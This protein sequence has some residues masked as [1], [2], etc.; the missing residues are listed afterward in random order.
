MAVLIR[1]AGD[2]IFNGGTI[3]RA[4]GL[5]E[6]GI[7]RAAVNV[8]ADDRMRRLIGVGEITRALRARVA[9][10]QEGEMRRGYIS[11]LNLHF[12]IIKRFSEHA[13]GRSGFKAAQRKPE[14]GERGGKP[15]CAQQAGGAAF[16]HMVADEDAA[17]QV[18]ARGDDD[19]PAGDALPFRVHAARKANCGHMPVFRQDL[20]HF[21][22][23]NIKVFLCFQRTLHALM[24]AALVHL[25]AER[26]HG[27]AFSRVE[28]AHLDELRIRSEAHLAAERINFTHEVPFGGAADGRVTGHE[29]HGIEVEGDDERGKPHARKRKRGL[30]AGMPCAEHHGIVCDGHLPHLLKNQNE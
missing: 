30:A 4:R 6:A 23:Q 17:F 19:G 5:N 26:M 3:P 20:G 16:A 21:A 9:L 12:G 7:H 25:R 14:R 2:F 29:R 8:C 18:Y 27:R 10:A 1:E 28:H 13:R 11:R 24:V 22:L 15:L